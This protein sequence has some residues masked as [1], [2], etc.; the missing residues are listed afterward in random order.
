MRSFSWLVKCL[1]NVLMLVMPV[2][3]NVKNAF[4]AAKIVNHAYLTKKTI[5]K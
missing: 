3:K 5:A 2:L 1:K 4:S